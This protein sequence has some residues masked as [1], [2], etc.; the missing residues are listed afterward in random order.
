MSR[1][2]RAPCRA[3]SSAAARRP[4][5]GRVRPDATRAGGCQ[6][7]HE[8]GHRG[9]QLVGRDGEELAPHADGLL[10]RAVE[11]RVVDRDRGAARHL[12]ASSRSARPYRPGAP[13][14]SE[15]T[16]S[17][18]PRATSGTRDQAARP[19][20]AD[21]AH[22]L[23]VLARG[24][25]ALVRTSGSRAARRCAGRRRGVRRVPA[26]RIALAARSAAAPSRGRRVRP[27]GAGSRVPR[28]RRSRTSRRASARTAGRGAPASPRSRATPRG[29]PPPRRGT[30]GAA[31]ACR[32]S[33]LARSS[34]FSRE[35]AACVASSSR[36]ASRSGV[37]A[38]ATRLFSR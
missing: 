7:E 27:R 23:V 32:A 4:R 8:R 3:A 35:M 1:V 15:S 20:L 33:S 2:S 19:Q 34:A 6:G 38:P 30:R 26:R 22:V 11:A 14:K 16:P 17:V 12:A 5:A 28:R 18:C 9:V 25:K 29:A 13:E 37:K 36:A 31:R 10:G 21:E 24:P